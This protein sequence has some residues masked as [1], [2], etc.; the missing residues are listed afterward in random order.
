MTEYDGKCNMPIMQ[1]L[2]NV[3]ISILVIAA[4]AF[5]LCGG[6]WLFMRRPPLIIDP[7]EDET[8]AKTCGCPMC[9]INVP[10]EQN[11]FGIFHR[12]KN[13]SLVKCLLPF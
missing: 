3:G 1:I 11:S 5:L 4:I 9:D 7:E 10:R 12:L 13:G 6:F 2:D 8:F